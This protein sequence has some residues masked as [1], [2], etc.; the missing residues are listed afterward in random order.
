MRTLAACASDTSHQEAEAKPPVEAHLQQPLRLSFE[1]EK[2]GQVT[3]TPTIITIPGRPTKVEVGT[4]DAQGQLAA[5]LFVEVTPLLEGDR[6]DLDGLVR[7]QHYEE[8]MAPEAIAESVALGQTYER[9][10]TFGDLRYMIRMIPTLELT[11]G[12]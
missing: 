8:V 12:T 2:E 6:V 10:V 4:Q 9:E 7:L 1:I 3:S 11:P 5:T